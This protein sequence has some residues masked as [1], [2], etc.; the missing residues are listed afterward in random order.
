MIGK[1]FGGNRAAMAADQ[2]SGTWPLGQIVSALSR[3]FETVEPIGEDEGFVVYGVSDR[4]INFIVALVTESRNKV[5]EIGFLAR[6]VGFSITELAVEQ[7]NRNLHIS[8]AGLE[9]GDDLYLLAG[10]DAVGAFSEEMFGLILEAWRRDLMMVLHFLSG[11]P[12]LAAAFPAARFEEARRFATNAA[13]ASGG[14]GAAPDILK[15]YLGGKT[16]KVLCGECGGRGKR[17]FI[18]RTCDCCDGSGFVTS[19]R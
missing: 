15:A 5:T 19:R 1:F 3:Q 11:R 14:E 12:S 2:A 7:M 9:E 18:A 6:F 13:P 10:I 17:G 8:V 4:G 16:T